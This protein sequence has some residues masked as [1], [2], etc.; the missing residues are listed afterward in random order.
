MVCHSMDAWQLNWCLRSYFSI[1]RRLFVPTL[2]SFNGHFPREPGLAGVYWSKGWWRWW[3]QLDYWSYKSC[4]APVKSS[5]PT[6]Q[7]PVFYRPDALPVAQ[8]TVS[9]HWRE[10][11]HIRWTCLLRLCLWPLIVPGYI[12]GELPCLSSALWFQYPYC[13]FQLL[14][15]NSVSIFFCAIYPLSRC[16][17]LFKIRLYWTPCLQTYQWGV[18]SRHVISVTLKNWNVKFVS[19]RFDENL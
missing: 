16:R 11:Y 2:S 4:K 7:R 12:G 14:L 15:G 18:K 10:K 13:S 5:L 3:R 8:P 17:F 9:K 1:L 19:M 6:N